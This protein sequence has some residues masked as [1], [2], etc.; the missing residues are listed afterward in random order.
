MKTQNLEAFFYEVLQKGGA[1]ILTIP[2]RFIS[3]LADV[4]GGQ[5]SQ[6]GAV[7]LVL[8]SDLLKYYYQFSQDHSMSATHLV[9]RSTNYICDH[10]GMDREWAWSLCVN[11]A[12]ALEH[13]LGLQRTRFVAEKKSQP[14]PTTPLN[15][16]VNTP[17]SNPTPSVK[18]SEIYTP[19]QGGGS[20][21]NTNLIKI[22]SIILSVVVMAG[23]AV[24]VYL[25][26]YSDNST[27]P[28]PTVTVTVTAQ[29]TASESMT[30]TPTPTPTPDPSGN[31]R[32]AVGAYLNAF[33]SD[34]N[35]GTYDSMARAVQPGSKM[36]RT[37]RSFLEKRDDDNITES[38]LDY[39]VTSLN[40]IN[41]DTFHVSTEEFYEIWMDAYPSHSTLKQRCTYVV[42]KQSDGSWKVC[43]FVGEEQV[44]ERNI[45][46][47]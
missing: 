32:E 1:E 17:P 41:D 19:P 30:P 10:F 14:V 28:A 46:E 4:S 33:V 40:K 23:L 27:E 42:K 8:K 31:V 7:N 22:L 6:I 12:H 43:D 18:K 25:N 35:R 13:H 34:V 44:V 20:N 37:Q 9:N 11:L 5:I 26:Y 29:P 16:S 24:F 45:I 21:Q 39:S 47:D 2:S 36:E 15:R 3:S 38:L